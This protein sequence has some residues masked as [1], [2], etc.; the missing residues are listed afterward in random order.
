MSSAFFILEVCSIETDKHMA[1]PLV[2]A[3]FVT[4]EN[5]HRAMANLALALEELPS[6]AYHV[7]ECDVREFPEIVEAVRIL[8]TPTLVRYWPLPKLD[9]IGDL[10]NVQKVRSVLLTP[11]IESPQLVHNLYARQNVRHEELAD[12]LRL[13]EIEKWERIRHESADT[14][15]SK[16]DHMSSWA[17]QLAERELLLRHREKFM[18]AREAK[19]S[20]MDVNE[21]RREKA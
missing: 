21:S 8:A 1:E 6:D 2:L 14:P 17:K 5:R 16:M 11:E 13:A 4:Q 12:R 15:F 20:E 7:F 10:S 3:L 9:I 18:D 19:N